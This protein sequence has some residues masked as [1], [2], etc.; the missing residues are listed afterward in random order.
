MYLK[1]AY[2]GLFWIIHFWPDSF[3]ANLVQPGA[4]FQEATPN[5]LEALLIDLLYS[6]RYLVS[7]SLNYDILQANFF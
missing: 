5:M 1:W 2:F 4:W 6:A 3:L 7:D